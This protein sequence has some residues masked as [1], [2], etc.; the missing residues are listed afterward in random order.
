MKAKIYFWFHTLFFKNIV[1]FIEL[2]KDESDG[3]SATV[4]V[5]IS[6][7][8]FEGLYSIGKNIF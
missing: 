7:F 8:H 1:S 5:S 6:K 4:S 3:V 2:E